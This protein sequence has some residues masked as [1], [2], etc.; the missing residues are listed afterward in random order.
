MNTFLPPRL[1]EPGPL[2]LAT[3]NPGKIKEFRDLLEPFG[4]DIRSTEEFNIDDPPETETTFAGNARLKAQHACRIA[5]I[6][7]LADD[8]GLSV[9][10]LDGQPG[11]CSARWA[12]P[13]RNFNLAMNKIRDGLIE[14]FG[15]FEH[16]D[17]HASFIAVLCLF[18]PDGH[19]EFFEGRVDGRLIA[20]PRGAGGFGYD[21][22]FIPDGETRTFAEMQPRE[23]SCLSHRARATRKLVDSCFPSMSS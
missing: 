8:S 2:L 1:F 12:G 3:H 22:I 9:R 13:E 10:G 21:P 7:A 15:S 19:G 14:R 6:P 4:I 18:W 11:I 23:K 5:G 20:E 16:A 17:H